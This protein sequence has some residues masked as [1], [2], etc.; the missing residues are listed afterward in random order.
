MFGGKRA[1]SDITRLAAFP[2]PPW[3]DFSQSQKERGNTYQTTEEQIRLVNAALYLRRPLLVTGAPGVG[4]SSLARA[5]AEALQLG[6]VFRWA[7]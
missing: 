4:K 5:V 1:N 3:R 6:P 2:P 7:I